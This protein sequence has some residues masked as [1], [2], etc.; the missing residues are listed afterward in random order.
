M[1]IETNLNVSPYFDDYNQ[2]KNFHKILFRP[3]VALQARELTQIQSILQNQIERFGDNIYKSG[4]IISGVNFIYNYKYDYAKILDLQVDGQPVDLA[5]YNGLNARNSS[6]LIAKIINYQTGYQARDPE[7]NY[8]FFKYLNAGNTGLI[9]SFSADDVLTIY[10]D[11]YKIYDYN[12][13]NGGVGFSNSDTVQIVSALV[14]SSSNVA[15]GAGISQTIGASTANVYI[16]EANSTFGSVTINGVT[17]SS[18]DGYTLLKVK[19]FTADLTNTSVTAT[20]WAISTGFNVVQGVN[21]ALVVAKVG[22]GAS[23]TLTTDGSGIITDVS[24]IN[25]GSDYDIAPYVTVRTSTGTLTN[26][27]ITAYN[28]KAQVTVASASYTAGNTTPVGNG[29][30]FGVTEGVIYQKGQFVRVEPQTIIV[31][32]YA[33]NVDGVTVGF[34]TSESIVNSSSD[35]TLLDLEP[36]LLTL[37][38]LVPIDLSLHL[39]Y[40]SLI[41]MLQLR[42]IRSSQLSNSA[43]VVQVENTTLHNLTLS[44]KSSKDVQPIQPA[45][46]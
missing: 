28:Y 12:V 24:A 45:I 30:A 42:I 31:N 46:M 6:G 11:S 25:N 2:E 36:V 32:A 35:D 37:Q 34:T 18:G 20:K 4:T 19:P 17:Y 14:V 5:G 44:Y 27:D 10:S 3:G 1:P 23:A 8:L 9:S 29:Y 15:S 40:K 22:S 33:S 26:I 13:V 21:T 39:L 16:T 7:T 41:L 38:H 43:K